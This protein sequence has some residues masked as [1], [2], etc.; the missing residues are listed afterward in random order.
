MLKNRIFILIPIPVDRH[1]KPLI[2]I[3]LKKT[4]EHKYV[5]CYFDN[6]FTKKLTMMIYDV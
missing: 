2:N 1:L 5:A 4:L 3:K 6:R